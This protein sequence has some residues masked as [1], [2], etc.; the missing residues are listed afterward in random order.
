MELLA[1]SAFPLSSIEISLSLSFLSLQ[2]QNS[3][4][5]GDSD[6][7]LKIIKKTIS[8]IILRKGKNQSKFW[9]ENF[10]NITGSRGRPAN[11]SL[12]L[13]HILLFMKEAWDNNSA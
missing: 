7:E 10:L 3:S 1:K 4:N 6:S 2:I 5:P 9:N 11:V 12:D 13:N 8:V